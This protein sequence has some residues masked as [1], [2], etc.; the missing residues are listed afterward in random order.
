MS[1]LAFH[2]QMQGRSFNILHKWNRLPKSVCH[3]QI[4]ASVT[5][6]LYKLC[7]LV[8]KK[9]LNMAIKH[10]L[11][12]LHRINN[13]NLP[14]NPI[15]LKFFNSLVLAYPIISRFFPNLDH[16]L[17]LFLICYF[18][19][20]FLF[21]FPF[22]FSGNVEI[23]PEEWIQLLFLQTIFYLSSIISPLRFY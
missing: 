12:V 4:F 18:Q 22:L 1:E 19:F 16:A 21:S 5:I 13:Q 2:I 20:N 17:I 14:I 6:N 11:Q 8:V 15:A 7:F 23:N 9:V 10:L 3:N